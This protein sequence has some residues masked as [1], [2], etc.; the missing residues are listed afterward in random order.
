MTIHLGI[1]A[2]YTLA[3]TLSSYLPG[4]G[5][6]GKQIPYTPLY[7]GQVNIGFAWKRLYLNYNH[8]YTG[9][10][11]ITTDESFSIPSYTIG[12]LQLMYNLPVSDNRLQ[13]TA[14]CSNL[15]NEHYQVVNARPMP[16]VNWLVGIAFTFN[17]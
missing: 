4:D 1:N 6:I 11:Y 9:L 3:T 12:N 17:K 15:W 14:Q 8:T 10:R 5:S 13:F 7:N 16:G 2:S